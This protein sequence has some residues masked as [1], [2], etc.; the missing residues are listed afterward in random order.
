V[1][2]RG[3]PI[4]PRPENLS[5][6]QRTQKRDT[7]L[8]YA[9]HDD[10]VPV[11]APNLGDYGPWL[12]RQYSCG[13]GDIADLAGVTA[14]S[15]NS[16]TGQVAARAVDGWVLGDPDDGTHEWATV[17]GGAGSWLTLEWSTPHTVRRVVLYDRPNQDDRVVAG[18]I[19]LPDGRSF[20]TG[21]LG[22]N[23]EPTV[24]ELPDAELTSLTFR[25]EEVSDTTANVGLAE[26]EVLEAN[27][28]P[29]AAV[30]AS[31]EAT[32]TGQVADRVVDG[33][34]AGY[35]EEP[36]HEWATLGGGVGSWLQLSWAAPRLVRRVLIH[37]RP[38]PDDG[39]TT[40]ILSFSDGTS[41][42][43]PDF[44]DPGPTVVDFTPRTVTWLVLTITGVTPTT[45]NTG[46]AEIQ[47]EGS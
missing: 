27:I 17:E 28:A 15:A 22:S 36:Q 20:P 45:Q 8:V 33:S 18:M 14:S 25:V 1:G 24:V 9:A 39:I 26:I 46:L 23:Y 29:D 13:T 43:V 19:L 3:Y 16:M 37:D 12:G 11:S 6:A 38:N 44:A 10:Q 40:A 5:A 41:I 4:A 31:S 7:F 2:H 42:D 35:P 34:A 30:S 32:A 47:V 21:T